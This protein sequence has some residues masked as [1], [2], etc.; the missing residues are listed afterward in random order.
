MRR[1]TFAAIGVGLAVLLVAVA[2]SAG[3]ELGEQLRRL[4]AHLSPSLWLAVVAGIGAL[5]VVV[6]FRRS[7]G[8]SPPS[9]RRVAEWL[10]AWLVAI[11]AGVALPVIVGAVAAL[12]ISLNDAASLPGV[13]A[14]ELIYADLAKS[15]AEDGTLMLRGVVDNG[16]SILYP[17]WNSPAYALAD[18]GVSAYQAVQVMNAVT[19]ALAAVP[20]Y[21]LARR[22]TT[23][24]WSLTVAL[25]SVLI[26]ATAYSALVMTE[27]LFY[28]VFVATALALTLTLERPTLA[29]QLLTVG[30]VLVLVAVRTQALALVPAVATAVVVDGV[31]TSALRARLQAFWPTW[32]ALGAVAVLALVAARIGSEAPTGSYGALLRTY[33]PLALARWTGRSTAGYLLETGVVV[34]AALPLALARL[35]RRGA[36][37]PERSLGATTLGVCAWLLASVAVLSASPYGLDV[38]HERSLFFMTPLVLACFVYWL[39]NGLPRP[40][41][42]TLAIVA[43]SLA[44]LLLLPSRLFLST[45]FVDSPTNV[46]W[47]GLSER[48]AAVPAEWFV[49]AAAVVGATV[50]L[51]ARTAVLPLALFVAVV[52]FVNANFTWRSTITS[53]DSKALGWVDDALADGEHATVVHVALDTDQCP[54]GTDSYQGEAVTWT[55]FFN[56]SVNRVYGVLGQVENDGLKTPQAT[57][58]PDGMLAGA[59]GPLSPDYAV[60]DSRVRVVGTELANLDLHEFPGFDTKRAGSLTLWRP[61]KP[62]RLVFPGPL[63]EGRP[64]LLACPRIGT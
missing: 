15:F 34:V 17:I 36:P 16:H 22:I 49:V 42:P 27:S 54:N 45:A 53:D 63:L 11:P 29:R 56:K 52:L 6:P 62:L 7:N 24:G 8:V 4:F 35:L 55:E 46:L 26:P 60:V 31:R 5:A 30:L 41:A 14:D 1:A 38:L 47:V 23:H 40:L 12:R 64:E 33:D 10:H 2:L 19:M 13:F 32:A 25:L 21:F 37:T 57:I 44:V 43:V 20:A 58:R 59:D 61:E 9:A 3:A 48:I 18:D 28:P 50:F 51:R 39:A